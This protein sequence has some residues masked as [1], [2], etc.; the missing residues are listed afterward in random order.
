MGP[1]ISE[2]LRAAMQADE[3]IITDYIHPHSLN[4]GMP[5]KD[6]PPPKVGGEYAVDEAVL[7]GSQA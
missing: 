6:I 4:N 5:T 7:E 1:N 2:S 3:A